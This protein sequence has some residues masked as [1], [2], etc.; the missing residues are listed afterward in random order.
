MAANYNHLITA[1]ICSLFLLTVTA[2]PTSSSTEEQHYSPTPQKIISV[3]VVEGI[4]YCQ[5]CQSPGSLTGATPIP[6]ARVNVNC[7]NQGHMMTFQKVYTADKH[8]YFYAQLDGYYNSRFSAGGGGFFYNPNPLQ[9]CNV[10]LVS[11][12]L[13]ACNVATDINSGPYGAALRSEN[14]VYKYPPYETVIYAAGPLAFRP[15]KCP[16]ELVADNVHG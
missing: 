10:K 13:R 15:S 3:V 11:S 2:F 8:G 9:A 6:Y 7:R 4:V 5:K 12:P 1:S 16:Y 14:K